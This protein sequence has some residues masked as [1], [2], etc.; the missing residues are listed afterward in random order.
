MYSATFAMIVIIGIAVTN[1][2]LGFATAML[3]GR[4]PKRLSDI[5]RAIVLEP[6][7]VRGWRP[8]PG[9]RWNAWR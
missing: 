4:G 9:Q 1:L 7:D 6:V 2:F 5:D 3:L 8:R